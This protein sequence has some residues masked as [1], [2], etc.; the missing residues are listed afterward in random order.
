MNREQSNESS[1]VKVDTPT[2]CSVRHMRSH[3][4][5]K[6]LPHMFHKMTSP[7]KRRVSGPDTTLQSLECKRRRHDR[8]AYVEDILSNDTIRSQSSS[9]E[10]NTSDGKTSQGSARDQQRRVDYANW[11]DANSVQGLASCLTPG[12]FTPNDGYCCVPVQASMR[13]RDKGGDSIL[14]SPDQK[15]YA[16]TLR[17]ANHETLQQHQILLNYAE[18]TCRSLRKEAGLISPT[19]DGERKA[20]ES[21]FLEDGEGWSPTTNESIMDFDSAMGEE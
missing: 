2:E 5:D 3:K 1:P 12:Q 18:F 4:A 7:Q 6:A 15:D 10:G 11:Q 14:A 21:I 8:V 9:S 19:S 13:Q 16:S 17:N 20:F